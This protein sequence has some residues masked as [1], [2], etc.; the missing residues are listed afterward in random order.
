V[1]TLVRHSQSGP[2]TVLFHIE[3]E[4]KF[5]KSG[6]FYRS[7]EATNARPQKPRIPPQPHHKNT[8][9]KSDLSQNPLQKHSKTT[10]PHPKSIPEKKYQNSDIK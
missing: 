2:L 1:S 7:T 9:L 6:M 5:Q 3:G 8:T 4:N 10:P